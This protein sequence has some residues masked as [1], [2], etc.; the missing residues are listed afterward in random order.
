MTSM[1]EHPWLSGV[2]GDHEVSAHPSTNTQLQRMLRMDASYSGVSTNETTALAVEAVQ[3]TPQD[4]MLSAA[5]D[6][7]PVW[8]GL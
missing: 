3:F 7:L 2:F 5:V 4:L 8:L 6:G 1:F